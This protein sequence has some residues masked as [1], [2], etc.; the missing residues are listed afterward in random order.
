MTARRIRVAFLTAGLDSGGSER[1]MLALAHGLPRDRFEVDFLVLVERGPHADVAEQAGARIVDLGLG[2]RRDAALPVFVV[3]LVRMAIRYVLTVR[4]RRYDLVDAWLYHAYVVA[5]ACRP[6]AGPPILVSGRRSL[7]D[8]KDHFGPIARVLDSMARRSSD[9]LVA[10]AEAVRRDVIE[11]EGADPA[12]LHV[13][14][15]GVDIP[16]ALDPSTRSAIRDAWGIRP[17]DLAIGCVANL[18]TGKGLE[19]LVRV[20]ARLATT[21][22]LVRFVVVGEGPLRA[23]LEQMIE[24]AGLTERVLLVGWVRDAR[25]VYAAF[26]IA[27]QASDTEG[28]PNVVLEAA[29]AGVPIVA[30]DAGGTNEI[31]ESEWTGLIVGVGDE[32]GLAAAVA[33][34][35]DDAA[36][37][38]RFGDAA[39]DRVRSE[40]TIERLVAETAALYESLVAERRR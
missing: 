19:M 1:Q 13:I 14:R 17:D 23:V 28:L 21:H 4:R 24:D 18:K 16:A 40:F 20:A 15:N 37:R 35:A 5:A 38:G 9:A 12:V 33:R 8:F 34:L 11:R 32:Q 22:P 3:R 30:T 31:I 39:R 27:V 26:D 25:R 36:L 10:N 29:A 2:R 6:I 7:S